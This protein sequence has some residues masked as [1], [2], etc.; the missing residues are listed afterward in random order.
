M[1]ESSNRKYRIPTA[2]VVYIY[3]MA[4]IGVLIAPLDSYLENG[5]VDSVTWIISLLGFIV[6]TVVI[7]FVL[8]RVQKYGKFMHYKLHS[9]E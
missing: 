2:R 1:T 9:R 3:F 5:S 8:Y 4:V 6:G 7:Q